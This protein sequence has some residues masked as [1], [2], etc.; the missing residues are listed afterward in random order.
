MMLEARRA[1][2]AAQLSAWYRGEDVRHPHGLSGHGWI[3][4]PQDTK[5]TWDTHPPA[6]QF[7]EYGNNAGSV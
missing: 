7:S 3:I 2:D 6:Y 4:P 1:K 5:R